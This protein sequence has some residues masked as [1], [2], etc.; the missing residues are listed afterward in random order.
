MKTKKF[1]E[2][3]KEVLNALIGLSYES[4][5]FLLEELKHEILKECFE[6][7]KEKK[8]KK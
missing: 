1:N 2:A 8:V 6:R 5:I 4:S 3:R 7:Y